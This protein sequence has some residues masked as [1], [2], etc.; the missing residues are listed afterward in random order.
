MTTTEAQ[1][2]LNA[3]R[4][5]SSIRFSEDYKGD[6]ERHFF[7]CSRCNYRWE[8]TPNILKRKDNI[9]CPNCHAVSLQTKKEKKEFSKVRGATKLLNST[10][11]ESFEV[12]SPADYVTKINDLEKQIKQA[13]ALI[14][15]ESRKLP[16]LQSQHQ[17]KLVELKSIGSTR[18]EFG[19]V[20][21]LLLF[22]IWIWYQMHFD[23][24]IQPYVKAEAEAKKELDTV[25][26]T[27]RHTKSDI[28]MLERSLSSAK[29]DLVYM[30]N[31]LRLQ[32][33]ITLHVGGKTKLY[34]FRFKH[35]GKKYYK[36]GI[37]TN[38]V[39]Y[40]YRNQDGSTY[41]AIEKVFFDTNIREA[42]RI[43]KLILHV[44]NSQLANDNTMLRT[45]GGYSEVFVSDVLGLDT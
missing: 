28:T 29:E 2:L 32:N 16:S 21:G 11:L 33:R 19:F 17:A 12:D 15:S 24:K 34:Y 4:N 37:T 43:E 22:P 6:K 36:I 8:S 45:K 23:A 14:E 7:H 10:T 26:N 44:F 20:F 13:K 39:H 25:T 42:E 41:G 30:K 9:G 18:T 38:S 35:D 31:I 5:D 27:I 40:R 1:K 3:K